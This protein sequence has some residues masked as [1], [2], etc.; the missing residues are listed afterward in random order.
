MG[1]QGYTTDPPL[2]EIRAANRQFAE[3]QK[4][5]KNAEKQRRNRKRKDKE[6]REKEN[7]EWARE[8]KSPIP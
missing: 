2:P 7:R 4:E 5:Q 8:G 1:H 3:A 6:A